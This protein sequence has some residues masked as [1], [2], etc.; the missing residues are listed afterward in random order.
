MRGGTY[1]RFAFAVALALCGGAVNAWA[2]PALC[3]TS[4]DGEYACQFHSTGG[5]GSFEITAPGKPTY[6]LVMSEPGVAFGF[7]NFG[8]RNVAL[9]GSYIRSDEDGACWVNDATNAKICAH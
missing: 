8:D 9:P 3:Y 7:V 6:S 5:D 1:C 4:D 2:K